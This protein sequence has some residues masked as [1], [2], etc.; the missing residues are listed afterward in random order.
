MR[1]GLAAFG[2]RRRA[3]LLA[4]ERLPHGRGLPAR[5][6]LFFADELDIHLLPKLG[7]EWMLR[8][9]QTEVLRPGTNQKSYLAGALNFSTGRLLSVVRGRKNRRLFVDLLKAI[10]RACPAAKLTRVYAHKD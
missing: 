1:G 6:A 10:G 9:T 7:C 3:L 4:H 8:G 2:H 5:A